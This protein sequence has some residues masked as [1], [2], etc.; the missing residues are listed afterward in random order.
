MEYEPLL[1]LALGAEFCIQRDGRLGVRGIIARV[2]S[3]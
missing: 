2:P 3:A 1:T